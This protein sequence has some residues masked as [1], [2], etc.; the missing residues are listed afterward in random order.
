MANKSGRERLVALRKVAQDSLAYATGQRAQR[1]QA[2]IQKLD[3][4]IAEIDEIDKTLRTF[5]ATGEWFALPRILER[6]H[7]SPI[8]ISFARSLMEL[9]FA[10][11]KHK[12]STRL[13]VRLAIDIK[14]KSIKKQEVDPE[15]CLWEY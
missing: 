5:L 6:T 15:P 4:R 13:F 8:Q 11:C 2:L 10:E 9:E 7:L 1:R 3:A 12:D 14:P